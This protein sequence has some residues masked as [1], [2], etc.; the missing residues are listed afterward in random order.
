[1]DQG[2]AMAKGLE[3]SEGQLQQAKAH[4]AKRGGAI[5]KRLEQATGEL[6]GLGSQRKLLAT[7]VLAQELLLYE[8]LQ[9]TRGGQAVAQVEGGRCLGCNMA[10]PT[11]QFQRA[12][13]GRDLVECGNCGRI[14][15][16]G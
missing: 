3:Q 2:D 13:S 6:Q 4:S 10:I 12:R 15:F 7:E 11:H 1:M 8:R 14:L 9:K 5:H 16:V